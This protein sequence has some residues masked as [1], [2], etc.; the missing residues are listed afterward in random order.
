MFLTFLKKKKKSSENLQIVSLQV[1]NKLNDCTDVR[2]VL[3]QFCGSFQLCFSSSDNS[4]LNMFCVVKIKQKCFFHVLT[5][6]IQVH[7]FHFL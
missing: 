2:H 5:E 4:N 3:L 1:W 6:K 7:S